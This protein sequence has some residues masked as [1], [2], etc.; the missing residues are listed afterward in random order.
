MYRHIWMGSKSYTLTWCL[1]LAVPYHG[2]TWLCLL[3]ETHHLIMHR[4]CIYYTS[5]VRGHSPSEKCS[6]KTDVSRC[7][8][9]KHP[10]PIFHFV[11]RHDYTATLLL[12]CIETFIN[13]CFLT[14][15]YNIHLL[16]IT[17][18]E[19]VN[20]EIA[21]EYFKHKIFPG[22]AFLLW[23]SRQAETL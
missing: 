1:I 23:S 12:G 2:N 9:C 21:K 10:A 13:C 14:N 16:L 11:K 15:K 20:Q 4:L 5:Y 3:K 8:R 7:N 6:S 19:K 18:Y 17:Q 22:I